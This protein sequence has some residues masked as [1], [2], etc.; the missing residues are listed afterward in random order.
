MPGVGDEP[1]KLSSFSAAIAGR[2]GVCGVSASR[3][4]LRRLRKC[5]GVIKPSSFGVLVGGDDDRRFSII[6]NSS[7]RF[8]GFSTEGWRGSATSSPLDSGGVSPLAGNGTSWA[9]FEWASGA[10]NVSGALTTGD[11]LN[12][13]EGL[14][15]LS[16]MKAMR[17]FSDMSARR[18]SPSGCGAEELV[19]VSA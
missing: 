2:V 8:G 12:P 19:C 18:C 10:A 11:E 6:E 3:S 1:R 4:G 5:G 15:E 14:C 17:D 16:K 9:S 13:V 7:L